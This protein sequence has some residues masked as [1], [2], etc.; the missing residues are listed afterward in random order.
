MYITDF[1]KKLS[2]KKKGVDNIYSEGYYSLSGM[3]FGMLMADIWNRL[4][5]PGN[6]SKLENSILTGKKIEKSVYDEDKLYMNVIAG[7][8]ISLELVGIK[9]AAASGTGMLIGINYATTSR[10]GSYIGGTP[11]P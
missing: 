5:M 4:D 11:A 8:I 3:L 7:L 9:G 1:L 10:K 6:D 2:N